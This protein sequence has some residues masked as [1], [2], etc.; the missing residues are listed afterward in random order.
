MEWY[1]EGGHM[2]F[3]PINLIIVATLIVIIV[4]WSHRSTP[5]ASILKISRYYANSP[6]PARSR[7]PETTPDWT[8]YL[9][10]NSSLPASCLA[11]GVLVLLVS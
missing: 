4:A 7:Q 6:R 3:L 2:S 8:N 5:R 11:F 1:N 9:I 10:F